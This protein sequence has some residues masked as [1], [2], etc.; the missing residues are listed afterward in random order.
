MNGTSG[1]SNT[2]SRTVSIL[3]VGLLAACIGAARAETGFFRVQPVVTPARGMVRITNTSFYSPV[4]PNAYLRTR[5]GLA[6]EHVFSTVSAADV[7]VTDRI[8]LTGTLPF[9]ADTFTQSSRSGRKTGPGDVSAGF[10]MRVGGSGT[11]PVM[12][13]GALVTVPERFG[14]GNEPLGFRTFSPGKP[15]YSLRLAAGLPIPRIESRLSLSYHGFPGK[16]PPTE[17]L[18]TDVFY[19]TGNG[20][21]GIGAPDADGRAALLRQ[22][23]AI[24]SLGVAVPV[25]SWAAATLEFTAARFTE[26]PVRDTIMHLTPGVRLGRVNGFNLTAGI[27]FGIAGPV[28]DRTVVLQVTIPGFSPTAAIAPI[29]PKP[30]VPDHARAENALV[31]VGS[32]RSTDG[33]FPYEREL[34]EVFRT[35]L[36]AADLFAITPDDVVDDAFSRAALVPVRESVGRLGVRLGSEFLITADISEY[37]IRRTTGLAIPFVVGFPKTVLTLRAHAKVTN[38]VTGEIADLGDIEAA[39]TRDRGVLFFPAGP[40]SDLEHLTEPQLRQAERELVDRWTTGLN[41]RILEQIDF[42]GWEPER[43]KVEGAEDVKG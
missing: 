9:Y 34:K 33:M 43:T 31:A 41:D 42:F 37:Y 16:K 40:S 29:I 27:D 6:D 20:Y 25:K 35:H 30:A 21:A 14:Y 17:T 1:I 3:T 23:H 2:N 19:D 28:P 11:I 5:Y 38:L 24:A 7:G 39:V 4:T 32:F 8:A 12:S 26:P 36:E 13:I 10:R 15:G 22:D 18:A